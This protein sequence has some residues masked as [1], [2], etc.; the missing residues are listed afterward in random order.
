MWIGE[1]GVSSYYNLPLAQ[2]FLLHIVSLIFISATTLYES[3]FFIFVASIILFAVDATPNK[4][5]TGLVQG[6]AQTLGLAVR[7][8]S[9]SIASSLYAYSQEK[10][11]LGGM[12]V[13]IVLMIMSLGA[14]RVTFF[15]PKISG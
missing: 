11:I 9:P 6:L 1:F 12:F 3:D 14:V 10:Q 4:A 2:L 5:S 8:F 15:L 13:Y 7:G